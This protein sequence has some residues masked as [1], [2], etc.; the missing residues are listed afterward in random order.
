MRGDLGTGVIA[1]G[2]GAGLMYL[3]DPN[4]GRRRRALLRD[5]GVKLTHSTTR[6][7]DKT[8]RD[9][10]NRIHGIMVSLQGGGQ[11]RQGRR[12]ALFQ[13]NW[14]P[15]VRL[16]VG[17]IGSIVT[18]AGIARRGL[19]GTIIGGL[20]AGLTAMAAT[21]FSI[22]HL[23]EGDLARHDTETRAPSRGLRAVSR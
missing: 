13:R 10:K 3:L 22:R 2:V 15:A 12:L 14:P 8:S 18:A 1:A 7:V 20:G 6:A 19:A 11:S 23:M 4:A 17:A 16:M 5:K 9:M 21:N